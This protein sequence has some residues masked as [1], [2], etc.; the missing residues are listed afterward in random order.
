[1][2]SV[3]IIVALTAMLFAV[4]L[5]VKNLKTDTVDG[6]DKM[7]TIQKAKDTVGIVDDAVKKMKKTME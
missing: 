6:V 3:F 2:R 5:V 1:M 4:F 7:E